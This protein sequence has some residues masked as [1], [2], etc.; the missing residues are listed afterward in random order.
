MI[1][2]H[3]HILPGVDDGAQTISD[4]L[5]MAQAAVDDGIHTIIATPHHKNGRYENTKKQIQ[6]NVFLLNDLLVQHNIPLTVLAGQETRLNGEF[7]DEMTNG[8]VLPLNDT[9]YVFVEFPTGQ[10]PQ[11]AKPMLFDI[12]MAGY[13]PII[14]HPERNRT[15]MKHPNKL[16]GFVRNGA[17]AQLTAASLVGK[18]GKNVQ[19]LSMQFLEA[20]LIHFIAT[21]AHNTTTRG[22][23]LQEAYQKVT[24]EYGEKRSHI[25]ME[26]S[27]LLMDGENIHIVEPERIRIHKKKKF[28]G[29][30]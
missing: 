24:K 7:I 29:L 27:Q 28:F 22:F 1:D 2:I 26:N 20:H 17:L 3:S 18:F 23:C 30:F 14:V 5:E 6:K 10:I 9:K 21:D 15:F 25:L 12:Q 8:E 4:S 19:K 11:Y 16:Y 13:Q